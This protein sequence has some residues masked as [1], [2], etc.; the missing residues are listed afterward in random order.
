M[1]RQTFGMYRF[2]RF[3][4]WLVCVFVLR[5]EVRGAVNVPSSKGCILASNHASYLDPMVIGSA[6]R[7]NIS[8]MARES[9]FKGVLNPFFRSLLAFPVKRGSADRGALRETIRRLHSGMPVVVFPE[10]TRG[11]TLRRPQAGVGF[12]ALKAQV[13]IVPVYIR[14]TGKALPRGAWVIRPHKVVVRFGEPFV[15]EK[16][17]SNIEAAELIMR[18]IQDLRPFSGEKGEGE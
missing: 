8:Y 16:E 6:T 7:R 11:L 15:I 2:F 10:G 3:L 17:M 4:S 14:G 9:L 5:F 12:L 13:P 18:R 1:A